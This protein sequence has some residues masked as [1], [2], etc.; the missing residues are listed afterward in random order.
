MS[1]DGSMEGAGPFEEPLSRLFEDLEQ[2]AE[3]LQ[4]A[5][6]DATVADLAEGE[7]ASVALAARMHAS[8]G[9]T[10][11]LG[12]VG[13]GFVHGRVR[14]VGPEWLGLVG[15]RGA[16]AGAAVSEWVVRIAAVRSARGL[17]G[18]AVHETARPLVARL[19][20]ASVLRGL[21]QSRTPVVVHQIDGSSFPGVLRRVGADFVELVQDGELGQEAGSELVSLRWVAAIRSDTRFG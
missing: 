7:Y 9:A 2:Q 14:R 12:I 15:G 11:R 16:V 1:M 4:L 17:S 10:V 3:A 19:G 20:V 6:R 8:V 18:Q 21:C 13:I 5:E